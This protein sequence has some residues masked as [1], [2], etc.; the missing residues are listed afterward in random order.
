MCSSVNPESTFL[1][2]NPAWL[3]LS[4]NTVP[5][6]NLRWNY[7]FLCSRTTAPPHERSRYADLIWNNSPNPNKLHT[8]LILLPKTQ[9]LSLPQPGSRTNSPFKGL[10]QPKKK[11]YITNR[12][13][14]FAQHRKLR[15]GPCVTSHSS[16]TWTQP[17]DVQHRLSA[18]IPRH[19]WCGNVQHGLSAWM[20]PH[21]NPRLTRHARGVR[22]RTLSAH[23]CT[24]REGRQTESQNC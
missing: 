4:A 19:H 18:W 3:F 12:L 2:A 17:G 13:L 1:S 23:S 5:Q 8:F 15:A 22:G 20:T 11:K 14:P 16:V 21:C 9:T 24:C 10:P 6:L 7:L